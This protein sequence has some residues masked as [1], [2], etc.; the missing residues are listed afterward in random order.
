MNKNA[1][2]TLIELLVVVL[3][4][5]ILASVALPQYQL[6]VAKAR[7][8]NYVQM[9]ASLRKAQEVYFLANGHYAVSLY[10]L[11]VDFTKACVIR[12]DDPSI[13]DCPYAYWDNV[14]GSGNGADLTTNKIGIYFAADNK[15]APYANRDLMIHVWF[16]NSAS[17]GQITCTE[18]TPFGARLC[19]N[20]NF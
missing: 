10:D 14:N 15:D 16:E 9:A 17:P 18:I 5:G 1:G 12:A 20:L 2:F 19:K 4:I 6:A 8:M 11:D 7:L 13:L 3:I